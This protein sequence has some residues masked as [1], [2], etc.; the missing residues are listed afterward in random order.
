M[1]IIRNVRFWIGV[2]SVYLII[3][4]V[5]ISGMYYFTRIPLETL[6]QYSAPTQAR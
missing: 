1:K 5:F 4:S 3:F 2:V 6:T